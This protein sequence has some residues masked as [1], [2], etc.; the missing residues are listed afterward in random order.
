MTA[1]HVVLPGDIDDPANPSGGNAYDRHVCRGL[2][3]L[4]WAVREHPVP[5]GWPHPAQRERAELAGLLGGLPDDAVV[6]LDGLV[7][8]TVPDVLT[9]HAG[10]L[11]LVVLV[12]LPIEGEAEGRALAAAT[13]VVATSDWTRR[14]LLDHHGLAGSRVVVAEPGVDPAPL[15]PGTPGGGRLLCVAAVTPIKGHDVLAAALARVADLAWTCDWVGPLD[16]D[17]RFVDRT[18]RRLVDTGLADRVRLTGPRTG[19]D[20]AAA[21]AAADLLVLPSRRE[22]YGMVVTEALARGVPV[23]A[24][25][26]GGLP[27]TL[28]HAPDGDRPGL[29]VPPEDPGATADALRRWLTDPALRDRLRRAARQRR[30]TLTG[31]PVTVDRLATALKE[32]TAA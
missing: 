28:G 25:D 5:G 29:L 18:R 23:L 4:G 14:R 26:T 19:D 6:L 20:L 12:H 8:S 31:W 32:A 7:A 27:A 1:V 16:R 17:P 30:H 24:G 13:A 10:R 11:R 21:Y 3:A 22:T 2:A 9:P 15:A